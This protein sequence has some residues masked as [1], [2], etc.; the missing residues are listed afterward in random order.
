M[1]QEQNPSLQPDEGVVAIFNLLN[2]RLE[3]LRKRHDQLEPFDTLSEDD[4]LFRP[5]R[6]TICSTRGVKEAPWTVD[7]LAEP[8]EEEG[9]HPEEV[10]Q[11]PS[12]FNTAPAGAAGESGGKRQ[13]QKTVSKVVSWLK[14]KKQS[15][16]RPS[17]D[18]KIDPFASDRDDSSSLPRRQRAGSGASDT[19]SLG[20]Q[21]L[22]TTVLPTTIETGPV[23]D[24]RAPP[25]PPAP[26]TPVSRAFLSP[27]TS[28]SR[29]GMPSRRASSHSEKRRS[30]GSAFFAFEFENGVVTRT[31]VDPALASSSASV[32]TTG[33]GDTAMPASPVRPRQTG[34]HP[35]LSPRVS[36]RFSKRIS[37]LPP[38][39]LDLLR[40]AS[41]VDDVPPIP[42]K[43]RE[44]IE[45]GYDKKLHPYAIRGLRD[46]EDALDEW[47]DWVA[48]LQEDE[49]LNGR[50][51]KSFADVVRV[52]PL[53]RDD[54]RADK[55]FL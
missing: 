25:A 48:S 10:V 49:E 34:D 15:K 43:F 45:A 46:Y 23:A 26:T 36:L 11:P 42:A 40:E 52:A 20:S 41:G 12:S 9:L 22:P 27:P 5:K 1:A 2:V 37:I 19:V 6:S 3:A 47:T 39:A 28:P 4:F 21:D 13:D 53:L 54:S 51:N 17:L 8:V 14:G 31:D 38:A 44:T 32:K 35:V 29:A 24:G 16:S 33:T 50:L 7:E 55:S 18:S 30:R